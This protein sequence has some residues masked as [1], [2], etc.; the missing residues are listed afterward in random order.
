M[1]M[2][3]R[4]ACPKSLS[5]SLLL[6]LAVSFVCAAAAMGGEVGD[7]VGVDFEES[8]IPNLA[9]L[10]NVYLGSSRY[11]FVNDNL[12]SLLATIRLP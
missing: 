1:T 9:R 11:I 7:I 10:D 12:T 5:R 4:F 2:E 8:A 3:D 6:G